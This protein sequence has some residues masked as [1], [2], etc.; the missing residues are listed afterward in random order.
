M[1]LITALAATFSATLAAAATIDKR[2][3]GGEVVP[4]G[5]IKW[6]VS[7]RDENGTHV[8]GGSLLDSTTVLTAAHCI[9][10]KKI[11]IFSVTAGTVVNMLPTLWSST[12][13]HLVEYEAAQG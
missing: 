4:E 7:L 11:K 5:E 12:E 10:N 13:V 6:I 1:V 9:E 2:I 3:V 8:C